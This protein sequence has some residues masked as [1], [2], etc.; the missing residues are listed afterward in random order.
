M[1]IDVLHFT[2]AQWNVLNYDQR[3]IVY[4]AQAE[5]NKL[6]KK[7]ES[8]KESAKLML[9]ANGTARST[10]LDAMINELIEAYEAEV[11]D[12]AEITYDS[13]A[14]AESSSSGGGGISGSDP[15]AVAYDPS[16]PDYSLDALD[17]F[18]AVK[19][20]YMAIEGAEVRLNAFL[21]DTT[22]KDYLGEYYSTML[23]Y[24]ESF[25]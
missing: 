16:S 22:A 2:E 4:D 14:N 10:L 23:S 24:L 5:K 11:K 19:E 9:I 17:R 20:Y 18:R 13:V 25:L 12:L 15:T 7:L 21:A 8:D 1:N 3:K 6:Q